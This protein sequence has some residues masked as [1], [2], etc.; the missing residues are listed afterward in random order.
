MKRLLA[1]LAVFYCL[2]I[3]LTSLF[4]VNF[5]A[6]L[7]LGVII[8]VFACLNFRKNH[9][10]LSLILLLALLLGGL[11]LKNSYLRPKCHIGNFVR[12]KDNTVY[13]L[14]GFID[15]APEIK[16]N[17]ASFVF[18]AQEVQSGEFKW[19]CCGKVLVN[20]D[21]VQELS[22]GDNLLLIGNL[23]RPYSFKSGQGY[24]EFLARQGIYL[25]M[26]IKDMR[27]IIRQEARSGS[28]LMRFSFRLRQRLESIIRRNLVDL[29]ASILSAMVLG[30]RRGIPWLVNNSMVRSGTVHI[31]VVSGFNVGIVALIV[32]LSLKIMR[33]RRKTRIILA[34]ICLVI[35]CLITGSSNPVIRATVMGSVFLLAYLFKRPPDIYNSLACAGLFILL[36]NPK[37]LFDVGFQLSFASVGAIVYLYPKLR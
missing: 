19:R 12:Y 17:R 10:F 8:L 6:I 13:S 34:V 25:L 7:G 21:F 32:N 3:I 35:Y 2:G 27:Q 1:V 24:K 20:L 18:R 14:S 22:Y 9:I 29:P 5:L 15:S 37:Q 16:D 31:L 36:I 26:R 11:N 28:G 33:V 4:R 23:R 30:Q